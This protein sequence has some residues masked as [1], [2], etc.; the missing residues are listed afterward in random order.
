MTRIKLWLTVLGGALMAAVGVYFYG[1]QDGQA[2]HTRRRVEAMQ[3]A[4]E[5]EDEVNDM[6]SDTRRDGLA[7]WMRDD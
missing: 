5:V 7:R 3:E 6:D 2:K 4:K 1:R